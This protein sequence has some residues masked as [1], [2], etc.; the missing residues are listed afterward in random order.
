MFTPKKL[1]V[2]AIVALCLLTCTSPAL[3]HVEA[4]APYQALYRPHDVDRLPNGHTLIT[5]GG[6]RPGQGEGVRGRQ[7]DG[8]QILEVDSA[9]NVVWSFNQGL[10]WA[11]NAD[12]LP[13][14]NTLISDTGHDR[15]IEIDAAGVIVWNSDDVTL[16]DGSVLNY[17]NDANWLPDDHLLITDRDNHRV[18]EIAR[19]GTIVW[20]FGETGAPGNDAAHLSGPHNADCLPEGN[21]IVADLA[22][23]GHEIAL[24]F[25]EDAH[26]PDADNR[27][28]E[29]WVTALEEEID[30][31]EELSGAEVRTWSGGNVYPHVFQA[32]E[33]VGLEVNINYKN[34]QT[35]QSDERFT[36]LAPWRPAGA[37]SVEERTTHDPGGAVIYIPSGVFPA[38][39]DKLEAFPRPYC[40]E[41]FDYVTV[42]LRNSLDAVTEG[43]VNAF[44]GTLH[45]SDFFGPGSDEDK[46]QVWDQWL[47]AVVDPLVADWRIQWAT[48][49][50]IADAF[51]A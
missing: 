42:A 43:K 45:P 12:R 47:T 9:G 28:V 15:V 16:S 1:A 13:N 18:I 7:G 10:N 37:A 20:Q 41:A 33:Q 4:D 39:C 38:H 34:P 26:I 46:L 6:Q 31:I 2:L 19:D 36:I 44:Y 51:M 24:H 17:P 50:D 23:Q 48:M 22:A 25:H 49:S 3:S 40:H 8:S 29:E 5:D 21:T 30:L 35:Q 32:A 27:P 11:H 14:G